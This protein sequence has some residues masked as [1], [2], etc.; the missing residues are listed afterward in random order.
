MLPFLTIKK[1]KKLRFISDKNIVSRVKA[2]AIY[3]LL[4]FQD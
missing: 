3:L 2:E 1:C 4:K